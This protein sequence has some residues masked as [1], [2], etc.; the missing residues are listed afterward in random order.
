MAPVDK[1]GSLLKFYVWK[2][3]SRKLSIPQTQT[4]SPIEQES[5]NMTSTINLGNQTKT[6]QM[7]FNSN[8]CTFQQYSKRAFSL[9][10]AWILCSVHNICVIVEDVGWSNSWRRYGDLWC[11][12]AVVQFTKTDEVMPRFA[13]ISEG[14]LKKTGGT[15]SAKEKRSKQQEN[16][17]N[18]PPW[19][20][21]W[22]RA[23]QHL[24]GILDTF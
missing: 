24:R 22:T 3:V 10:S 13:R 9:I 15:T 20:P 4:L 1:A 6:C 21:I 23:L 11:H 2:Y 17:K 8:L 12:V 18:V 16:Q 7:S 5:M 19:L 14:Q